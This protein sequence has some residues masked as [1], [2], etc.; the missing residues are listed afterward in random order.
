MGNALICGAGGFIGSHLAVRLKG[1][2]F[3]VRGVDPKYPEFGETPADDFVI[4]ELRDT[5]VCRQ[6]VDRKFE[7]D[8]SD[9]KRS[10]LIN[11]WKKAVERA[12]NWDN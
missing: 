2:G 3:W 5:H 4:G 1:E 12:K 11:G 10:S 7:S 8:I 9:Q 6:V